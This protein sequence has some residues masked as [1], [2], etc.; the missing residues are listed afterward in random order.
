[1]KTRALI[2]SL[3][4]A[5][6]ASGLYFFHDHSERT[7]AKPT[8]LNKAPATTDQ[9]NA[10]LP[11]YRWP[12]GSVRQYQFKNRTRLVQDNQPAA[13]DHAG[14]VSV[15]GTL[16]AR[17]L[18]RYQGAIYM[19]LQLSPAS[20]LVSGEPSKSLKFLL[21]TTVPIG[22]FLPTGRL[23]NLIVPDQLEKRDS[24]F[25]RQILDIDMA[26]P[27]TATTGQQWSLIE[28]DVAGSYAAHFR[29]TESG[30]VARQK[31]KYT[32]MASEGY[33][34]SVAKSSWSAKISEDFWL[35]SL[36]GS[37]RL[38]YDAGEAWSGTSI[39]SVNMEKIVS[40]T[41]DPDSILMTLDTTASI[42]NLI[43]EIMVHAEVARLGGGAWAEEQKKAKLK[44]YRGMPF[45]QVNDNLTTAFRGM[46]QHADTVEAIHELRDWILANPDQA[47]SITQAVQGQSSD[48]L[49][50][51]MIHAL[52][53]AGELP[54]AQD[55]LA[56]ILTDSTNT[57][58]VRLQAA[59]A[60]GGIPRLESEMLGTAL[61]QSAFAS[62]SDAAEAMEVGDSSLLALGILAG[63]DDELS[64]AL[65]QELSTYLNTP[66]VHS[67]DTVTA[68]RTL[69][70]AQSQD[71]ATLERI[72]TLTRDHSDESVRAAA[73]RFFE[74]RDSRYE[75]LAVE[76][77]NDPAER[78]QVAAVRTLSAASEMSAASVN[79]LIQAFEN[80]QT[81]ATVRSQIAF[82]LGKIS[83]QHPSAQDSLKSQ[84]ATASP[85]LQESIKA[86]LDK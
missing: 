61:W 83:Q 1:M 80:D 77:L 10:H 60:A 16:T 13:S 70:N 68:I 42:E 23:V 40:G 52:E 14:A 85:K 78:V 49:T 25:L 39:F 48:G 22:V 15:E 41:P 29:L 19:G 37:E 75:K 2:L 8:L 6:A 3:S 82:T 65:H 36:T 33:K 53:L 34:I 26:L 51:R 9:S 62:E 84:L 20:V 56:T 30:A 55:A 43:A 5:I 18:K 79:G 7:A 71:A 58:G 76:A 74:Q 38:D 35:E 11:T 24:D 46:T 44:K 32:E 73:V 63:T 69:Q 59:V 67:R 28:S 31:S 57:Q 21:E 64:T 66:D 47:T 50:A 17:I 45:K 81:P 54:E 72:E 86:A 27:E 4:I 12:I